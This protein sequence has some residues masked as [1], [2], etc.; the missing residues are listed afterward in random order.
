MTASA[1][2][3]GKSETP[4][5]DVELTKLLL[6]CLLE[7]LCSPLLRGLAELMRPPEAQ[8]PAPVPGGVL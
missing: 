2:H 8:G 7:A 3:G 4:H 5:P 1:E 6:W